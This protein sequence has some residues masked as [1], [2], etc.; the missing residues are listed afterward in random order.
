MRR[1]FPAAMAWSRPASLARTARTD[2]SQ[3]VDAWVSWRARWLGGLQ[4][5]RDA[6]R[7]VCGHAG[8]FVALE[9][10]ELARALVRVVA[11][12]QRCSP[13]HKLWRVGLALAD[14]ALAEGPAAPEL[15]GLRVLPR[16]EALAALEVEDSAR[17][18]TRREM[19]EALRTHAGGG[20]GGR[21]RTSWRS[22]RRSPPRC[23]TTGASRGPRGC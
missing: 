6:H 1:A 8:D 5:L 21:E 11:V 13:L 2:T 20:S 22:T 14:A 10:Q 17:G 16:W 9:R 3:H 19:V 4:C 23:R 18:R 15:D 7:L 12:G